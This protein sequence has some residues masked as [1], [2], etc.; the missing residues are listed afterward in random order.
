M[1]NINSAA[2]EA[3]P[4]W[5]SPPIT[6]WNRTLQ[7]QHL[8]G[9]WDIQSWCAPCHFVGQCQQRLWMAGHPAAVLQTLQENFSRKPFE[10]HSWSENLFATCYGPLGKRACRWKVGRPHS[11]TATCS[12]KECLGGSK[13]NRTLFSI[14]FLFPPCQWCRW[15]ISI[16]P[17]GQHDRSHD[18]QKG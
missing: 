13:P 7:S 3:H 6:A 12:R 9:K 17:G 15:Q 18:R 5:A 2:E 16:R 8:P 10:F 11:E 4:D 14:L 1:R